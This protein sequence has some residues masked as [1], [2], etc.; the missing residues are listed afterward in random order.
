MTPIQEWIKYQTEKVGRT[1]KSIQ[2][3]LGISWQTYR[4]LRETGEIKKVSL[5]VEV[6]NVMG[7]AI[8][9]VLRRQPYGSEI[10]EFVWALRLRQ[11]M[12]RGSE[13]SRPE[14]RSKE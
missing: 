12:A 4:R 10:M 13:K 8:D 3:S 6:A 5:L 7:T 9:V 14:A 11:A 1:H 2:K